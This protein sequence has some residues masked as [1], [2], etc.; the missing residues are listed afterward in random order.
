MPPTP[1]FMSPILISLTDFTIPVIHRHFK[2]HMSQIEHVMLPSK[3]PHSA[4]L[5]ILSPWWSS[6]LQKS[7][8][9]SLFLTLTSSYQILM[10]LPPNSLLKP[11]FH[12]PRFTPYYI[13]SYLLYLNSLLT[14]SHSHQCPSLKSSVQ[15][16]S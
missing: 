6:Y 9:F 5:S 15:I 14:W 7:F 10:T 1:K 8:L 16:K 13:I 3:P 11:L 4:L 2:L 12:L